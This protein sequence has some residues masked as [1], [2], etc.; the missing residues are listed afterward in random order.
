MLTTERLCSH[1]IRL[2]HAPIRVYDAEG[3]QTAV[4]V[5]HGEQQDV[6]AC[7]S[8]FLALLLKKGREEAPILHL[9]EE[10][11][12]YGIL[13]GGTD[14]Y[15]IGPCCFGR[16]T[17]MAAKYLIRAHKMDPQRPYRVSAVRIY[18]F[19]ELMLVLHEH[20]TGREM[21]SSELIRRSFCDHRFEQAMQEKVHRVFYE[22]QESGAVHNPYGQEMREQESIR[23]GDLERLYRSFDEA[24]V[25]EIGTLARE[26]LRQAKNLAIV[27]VT[28]ASRSAIAGG[29]LPEIA[30]SMSDAFIQRVEEMK[31]VGET[32]ALA[33]QSEVEF[34]TAVQ[35]LSS[36]RARNAL[37]E[38]C[39][40]L[41]VR[42]LHS[43]LSV[44]ELAGQLQVTPS[45]LSHLF[46]REE[47]M[48]LTDYI[49]RE[50]IREAQNHL[51]YTDDS[52][53]AV[54]FSLGFVSQSH[55]GQVF[56]R[57]AGMTP[58]QYRETYGRHLKSDIGY[59]S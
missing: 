18:V 28:L 16:D 6:F 32:T 56:K 15:M 2:L 3:K 52:Y 11:T 5:D 35:R 12:V 55:F 48:K 24:Y 29:V 46:A 57:W 43:K 47:G 58:K 50:K 37:V 39:K 23:T 9:E 19:V 10:E 38:R 51:V 36:G 34:C 33:R 26:P 27:L 14:I 13:K 44:K 21:E 45:H 20:L 8:D 49:A 25:G 30:F 53:E 17:M 31:N 40:S 54:A 4:Y 59:F 7:D 1:I 42:Q 41:I 22:F